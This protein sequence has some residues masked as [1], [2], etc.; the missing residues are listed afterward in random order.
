MKKKESEKYM[1]MQ[2]LDK[3]KLR[4]LSLNI[5]QDLNQMHFVEN[6]SNN[7]LMIYVKNLTYH[8]IQKKK[9]RKEQ[10]YK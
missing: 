2:Y 9:R 1:Y 6:L 3:L 7:T 4:L 10:E 8:N 5:N